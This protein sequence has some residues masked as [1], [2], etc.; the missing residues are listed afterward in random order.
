MIFKYKG[1]EIFIDSDIVNEYEEFNLGPIAGSTL[2][3]FLRL[4][5]GLKY[6]YKRS[7]LDAFSDE[8][9]SDAVKDG[10]YREY[11]INHYKPKIKR[12]PTQNEVNA[13][14]DPPP[15]G[16]GIETKG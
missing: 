12:Y 8:E 16:S 10:I 6:G 1:R 7:E 13:S 11:R 14:T 5:L 2:N 9:L 4:G 3:V 15:K